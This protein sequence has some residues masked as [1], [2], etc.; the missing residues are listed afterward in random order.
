MVI[1]NV[2]V[3][4]TITKPD[5]ELMEKFTVIAWTNGEAEEARIK[6]ARDVARLIAMRWETSDD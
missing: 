2:Q 5:G 4:V 3:V 1:S 6:V